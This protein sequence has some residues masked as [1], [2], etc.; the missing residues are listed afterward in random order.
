MQPKFKRRAIKE[1]TNKKQLFKRIALILVIIFFTGLIFLIGI[2]GWFA[3]QLPDPDKI[4]ARLVAESTKI[5]SR[6]G[7]TLLYETG[8]DI[9]RT[10][11]SLKEI[12]NTA[13]WATIALEDKNFYRHPGFSLRSILRSIYRNIFKGEKVGGSTITQQFIK[14]AVLGPQKTYARKIKELIF[15]IE[16]ERKYSKDEILEM[17]LNEIPYGGI[18]YGIVAASQSYFAKEPKD[19]TLA[20]AATLASLPKAP[21]YYLSNLD[22]LKDRRDYALDRMV[23]EGYITVE[24]ANNAKKEVLQIKEKITNIKAPHFVFYVLSILEE[25][26][27]PNY[28]NQGLKV[29]TTLDWS[30]QQI[31][32]EAI[33]NGMEKVKA[34]GGSNAALVSL[35]AK[36]GEILAMVGGA[37]FWDEEHGGQ[38]NVTLRP[39]QPGSS[40]K[41]VVYYTAFKMGYTP[42]TIL[43]DLETNFNSYQPRNYTGQEYGPLT[44]R[45]ALA[46]SL[47]IPAVKTLYLVGVKN[48]INT[49]QTLGYTTLNDPDRYGLALVL[50]GAEVK[51]LEHTSA[52]ATLARE[53]VYHPVAAILK[54]EKSNGEILEEWKLREEQV[55]E[56]QPV[57][58]ITSILTDNNARAFIFGQYNW[59][60]LGDRPVAAK[61]GTTNDNRD[62]WTMGYTPSYATGVWV[63]NNDNSPMHQYADG[64]SVAAP[65]WNEYM[66][67]ILEN[68]PIETFKSPTPEEVDKPVLKGE[69]GET[70]IKKVDKVTGEIIPDECLETYPQN[71]IIEKQFRLAHDILHYVEKR[72]PRGPMPK[73]PTQDPMYTAWEKEV[74]EWAAGQPDYLTENNITYADCQQRAPATQPSV[75]IIS[76]TNKAELSK[77]D[78]KIKIKA[79]PAPGH[80]L[81]KVDFIIDTTTVESREISVGIEK[82]ITSAYTAQNLTAGKHTLTVFVYDEKGNEASEVINFYF[83]Q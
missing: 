40:F 38:V 59:L 54:V 81:V 43:F 64:G 53:G 78:F 68:T 13:Q 74:Q 7:I 29:T 49:A 17:Y 77:K 14:N 32:E 60:T 76:P 83:K 55:L 80:L 3:R 73:D 4:A 57:R 42:E 28:L 21:N 12:P 47:N 20:E 26:Y 61:T 41:P 44:M 39:R 23:E 50:G 69:I 35:D 51:L 8:R 37:N 72:N 63:G 82:N 75:S 30:K 27:G 33:A 31:A 6:D 5:Y 62:G 22:E 9:R 79:R 16:I 2:F 34:K 11:I 46:G 19:L 18:N 56:T 66:R 1:R 65:I 25:K 10:K 67:R 58:Q 15:A 70:I 71:Y 36:T 45:K 52:Y 24:E 48:A